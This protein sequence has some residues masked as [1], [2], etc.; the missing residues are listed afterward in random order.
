MKLVIVTQMQIKEKVS[1]TSICA[2]VLQVCLVCQQWV[3]QV[4]HHYII[5]HDTHVSKSLTMSRSVSC[6]DT[7][8]NH[9]SLVYVD[10]FQIIIENLLVCYH[11]VLHLVLQKLKE[12]NG[13]LKIVHLNITD[14]LHVI[15]HTDMGE[16]I[17]QS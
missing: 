17:V 15:F 9:S 10:E 1:K 16:L 14:R 13:L 8:F 6:T 2:L 7:L 4:T 11:L 5:S 12:I 3:V